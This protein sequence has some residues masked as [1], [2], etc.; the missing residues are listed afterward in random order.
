MVMM[1]LMFAGNAGHTNMHYEDWDAHT[2]TITIIII[3]DI[4]NLLREKGP[5]YQADKCGT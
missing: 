2:N 1:N 5:K 4:V 3:F